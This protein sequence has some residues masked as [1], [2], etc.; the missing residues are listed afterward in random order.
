M[1]LPEENVRLL[2]ELLAIAKKNVE[3]REGGG[4]IESASSIG[5]AAIPHYRI[6]KC[7]GARVYQGDRGGWFCDIVFD[8]LPTGIPNTLASPCWRP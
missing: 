2:A 8:G 1:D 3:S 4:G 6:D 5:A 7:A